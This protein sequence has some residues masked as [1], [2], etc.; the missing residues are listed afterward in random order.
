MRFLSGIIAF[1]IT[2]GLSVTT[3]G[4]LFGFP[5]AETN[6]QVYNNYSSSAKYKIKSLITRDVRNGYY[7]NLKVRKIDGYMNMSETELYNNDVYQK[8]INEY[9]RRS[10]TI[11]DAGLPDDFKYAW[12]MH[13]KAWKKQ[14]NYLN[15]L[16][17]NSDV[18]SYA[19]NTQEINETWYQVLRIAQR[20]GV[21][22]HPRY[23]R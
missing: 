8:S 5:K 11:S 15:A 14:A 19:D 10:A 18:S 7:R 2:F 23:Y 12:R 3:V 20:Y 13:M 9:V 6:H 22:I 16:E 17:F 21:K 1:I 4:L